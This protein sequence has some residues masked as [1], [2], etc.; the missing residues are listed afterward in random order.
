MELESQNTRLRMERGAAVAGALA[1]STCHLAVLPCTQ[2]QSLW[3]L[4]Q[5]VSSGFADQVSS[6]TDNP[7]CLPCFDCLAY[8]R[9]GGALPRI[10]AAPASPLPLLL[11]P[12]ASTCRHGCCIPFQRYGASRCSN[13]NCSSRCRLCCS[14]SCPQHCWRW[15]ERK[16]VG[17]PIHPPHGQAAV[18]QHL[19]PHGPWSGQ[20][21]CPRSS[22]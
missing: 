22:T 3:W 18:P 11:H 4:Q 12:A 5:C 15:R 9:R 7:F 6:L 1:A 16:R 8:G 20:P 10:S 21:F 13:C 19:D 14:R 2:G 17:H